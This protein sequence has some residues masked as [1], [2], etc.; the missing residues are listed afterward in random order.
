MHCLKR[1]NSFHI[2]DSI[3]RMSNVEANKMASRPTHL[4]YVAAQRAYI[5]CRA[6]HSAS[7][8]VSRDGERALVAHQLGP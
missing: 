5:R 8:A 6:S 2:D 3:T 7:V 4:A 1:V